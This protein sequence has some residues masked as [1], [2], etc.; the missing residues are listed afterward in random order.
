M[1]LGLPINS[2]LIS[3][4]VTP[5]G[6]RDSVG[7]AINLRPPDVPIEQKDKNTIGI[8]SRWLTAHFDTCLEDAED[9][10]IQRY[11]QSCL[12]HMNDD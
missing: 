3:G 4:T 6:W 9:A 2:T 5:G 8:H 1:I 10:V 12:W 11:A 7:A